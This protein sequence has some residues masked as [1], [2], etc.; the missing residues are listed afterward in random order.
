[1]NTGNSRKKYS[2]R[3]PRLAVAVLRPVRE[4]AWLRGGEGN[5][6]RSGAIEPGF[7]ILDLGCGTGSLA[8]LIKRLHP[9]VDVIGLDPDPR[10]LVRAKR[11]AERA[12][13]SIRLDQGFADEMP[14][15]NGTFDSGFFH[16]HVSPHSDR[17]KRNGAKRNPASPNTWSATS[18]CS[19]SRALKRPR[20]ARSHAISI[21]VIT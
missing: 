21:R 18:T 11:K 6:S 20:P 4:A 10:A 2:C 17:Q 15:K 8:I 14:Y 3:Q 5:A 13:I 16:L 7:R 1:M 19:I 12:L 9:T